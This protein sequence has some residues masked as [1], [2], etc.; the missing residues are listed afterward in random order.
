MQK[1][2]NCGRRQSSA[3]CAKQ[4]ET[5][6][7]GRTKENRS[8]TTASPATTA[9]CDRSTLGDITDDNNTREAMNAQIL[10]IQ[11]INPSST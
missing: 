5:P 9:A 6:K 10:K 2:T 3:K 7:T 11:G 1:V 8:N 4:K